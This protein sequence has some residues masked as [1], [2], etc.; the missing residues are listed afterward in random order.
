MAADYTPAIHALWG[1]RTCEAEGGL[2]EAGR[3]DGFEAPNF[4]FVVSAVGGGRTGAPA[5][6]E[7]GDGACEQEPGRV[8]DGNRSAVVNTEDTERCRHDGDI[9]QPQRAARNAEAPRRV[10][11]PPAQLP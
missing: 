1:T 9:E 8:P 7:V 4:P 3:W 6:E 11:H 5:E 10:R 2:L